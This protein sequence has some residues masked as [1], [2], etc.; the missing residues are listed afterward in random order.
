MTRIAPLET[1]RERAEPLQLRVRGDGRGERLGGG[2]VQ[3]AGEAE[4]GG[5]VGTIRAKE[6]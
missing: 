2:R 3:A 4:G 5:R 1:K 6:R